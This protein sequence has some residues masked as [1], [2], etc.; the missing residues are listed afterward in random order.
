MFRAAVRRGGG[1]GQQT[2]RRGHSL[3]ACNEM[4]VGVG[5]GVFGVD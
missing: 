5:V 1:Q 2:E 4:G 3:E